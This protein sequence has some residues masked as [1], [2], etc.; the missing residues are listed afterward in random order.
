M[1]QSEDTLWPK[2]KRNKK[3]SLSFNNV[4]QASEDSG[5]FNNKNKSTLN[6]EVFGFDH[7]DFKKAIRVLKEIGKC[8]WMTNDIFFK[9]LIAQVLKIA[10]IHESFMSRKFTSSLMKKLKSYE[11][12]D[13][14]KTLKKMDH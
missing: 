13:K 8:K 4:N 3:R 12:T 10:H 9:P 7:E 14:T 2:L 11:K 5:C 1:K 6:R